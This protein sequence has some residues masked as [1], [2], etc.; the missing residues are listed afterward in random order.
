MDPNQGEDRPL[1]VD[2]AR[3]RALT[4]HGH[5]AIVEISLDASVL[6]VSPRFTELFGWQPGEIS[7]KHALDLIH[8]DDRRAVESI[9]AQSMAEERPAQLVFRLA[10]RDGSWRWVELAGSPYLTASGER[11]AVGVVRDVTEKVA[12]A[13]ALAE[14]LRAEQRIAQLSRRF[15]ALGADGFEA[16]IREGLQAAAEIVG[17]ERA[18]FFAYLSSRS[19]FGGIFEWCRE[20]IPGRA[21]LGGFE[22]ASKDYRWSRGELESGRTIRAARISDLPPAAE[23]ERRSF[24]RAGVRSYLAIPVRRDDRV[25]GFLDVFCHRTQKDWSDQDVS[26]LELVAEVFSTALRRLRAEEARAATDERFRR[27]TERARDAICEIT[28]E[29][30]ILYASPSFQNLF[31]FELEELD[32]VDLIS[33]VHPED[34]ELAMRLGSAQADGSAPEGVTFRT[35]HRDGSWRWVETSAS[36]FDQPDGQRR[37]A[38]VI[39]DAGER[40][41]RRR[42]LERQLEA[43][44]SIASISRELLGAT[45][46]AIEPAI[47]RALATAAA[48]GGADR[49][50]LVSIDEKDP[51][52]RYYDCHAPGIDDHPARLSFQRARD[53]KWALRSLL[54]GEPVHVPR[55]A[56]LPEEARDARESLLA[57]GVQSYLSVPVT[58]CDRLVGLL[59]FHCIRS[60][61]AWSPHEITWLRVVADLFTSALERM[62]SDLA[63]RESEER[64][65]ALAEHAK[66]PICEFSADG[67]FLYA[68]PSFTELMGYSREELGQIRF[69]DFVHPDDHPSLIRKYA[70]AEGAEGMGTSIYRGRH[71]DGSW[72]TLEATARMFSIAGGARRVVAVLRD[73]TE[74][75]RSQDA[76]RHQLGLETRIAELSRRFLALPAEAVDDE[77]RRSLADLAAVSGADRI[78]MVTIGEPGERRP[79]AF[80]W[81]GPGI[82]NQQNTFARRRKTTFPWAYQRLASGEVIQIRRAAELPA[83]AALERVDLEQRGVKS[84]LC[85]ALNSEERTIGY[86]IFE[87]VREE[88]SWPPET[89]MPL[90]LMGEIFVGALRRKRA[91]ESLAESQRRLLQAQ[92][93]EAVGT[94]AGGIAH[95]FN[96]QLTVMLGNARYLL[97]QVA[98]NEEATDAVTDLKRAAE[99][100]AQLT[101]SLLAFSRRSSVSIRSLD[102][103]RAIAEVEELLR[104]LI[105]SSIRFEVDV[106]HGVGRVGADPTQLQQVIVNLAVNARDAMPDGGRL[107][108]TAQNRQLDAALA[109]QLSAPRPGAYVEI[110]VADSGVGIDPAI[111][112]RIFEPFFTTKAQ[113]KGTGL[114][115]ATV[116]GIVQQSAGTIAVESTPGRGAT[117]RVWLP[118]SG[119]PSAAEEHADPRAVEIGRERVLLVEDEDS[120]RRWIARTLRERGYTVREARDGIEALAAAE[121]DG[122]PFDVLATDVDMPRL[123]GIELARRLLLRRP[124]LRVL[125]FSGSSQEQL[126]GPD[127]CVADSRFLQKPFP[128]EALF[129]AL[130]SLLGASRG[131]SEPPPSDR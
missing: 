81:C 130:R 93:M 69:A 23:P 74:R 37:I 35:R 128:A 11:R 13:Q 126:E 57:G 27:L 16:G 108:I 98:G 127:S 92:K 39:R 7:G 84:L 105:P 87:T 8:P 66:D 101:R 24:E 22:E 116:Y 49:C 26:R 52:L 18:Q 99:H 120:V 1:S 68:S 60:E 71:R 124:D 111:R 4:E 46:T 95:D 79:G 72:V 54:R 123:S 62:R 112:S 86:L 31:G 125:F 17:A 42:E 131:L 94:L 5:D 83:E 106:P 114:G 80:E 77:V 32:G 117:F 115:L 20:G 70:S 78:W 113:G 19:R 100:C 104:P 48:L 47:R 58:I 64:F 41:L 3:F 38:L 73:V 55:V 10:H 29:G 28:A 45:G 121:T 59:G 51:G 75:Q 36:P 34:R 107:L 129:A 85:I 14:Q 30:R 15:L 110:A 91:E 103:G 65:R 96:N 89:V 109:D 33:L 90:R 44:K 97:A 88:R 6:Y 122:A 119:S 21:G 118:C 67:Q 12:G 53:Q 102:V 82:P 61:K 9:R 2:P 63:L 76:L 50:Y 40:E 25:V 43:E 56:D